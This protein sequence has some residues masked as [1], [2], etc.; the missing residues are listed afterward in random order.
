M[1]ERRLLDLGRV[2]VTTHRLVL[3][4]EVFTIGAS[5]TA[6]LSGSF[7]ER[8]KLT[9]LDNGAIVCELDVDGL[10]GAAIRDA[11]GRAAAM[12]RTNRHASLR[13]ELDSVPED[14]DIVSEWSLWLEEYARMSDVDRQEA[15]DSLS[16]QQREWVVAQHEAGMRSEWSRWLESY[17]WMTDSK[18]REALAQLTPEQREW[19]E[20]VLDDGESEG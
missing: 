9:L 20:S 13:S 16:S 5:T 12:Q 14:R 6:H 1:Q 15:L 7:I 4:D 18:K 2:V 11:I 10:P 3:G 17:S 8:D 19:V